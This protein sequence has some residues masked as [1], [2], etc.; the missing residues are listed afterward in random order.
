MKTEPYYLSRVAL[1]CF[2]LFFL[3]TPA[4]AKADKFLIFHLDAISAVDFDS[5]LQAG[6]LPNVQALFADGRYIKYGLSPFPGGTEIIYPRLKDGL[7]NSQHH[8]VAWSRWDR[9]ADQR[10]SNLTTWLE[11]VSGFPRRNKHQFL[12]A[13]PGLTHLAGL[14]LLNIERLWETEDVIEFFWFYTDFAGHL[15]GPEGHLKALRRFD[16]YL[17]LLLNTGRLNG[18]N[19]VLYTDHG[20][21]AGDVNRVD[22]KKII[23]ELLQDQLQ[24]IDYPNVYLQNPEHRIELAQKVIKHSE[25]DLVLVKANENIVR[26]FSSE[27]SFEIIKKGDTLQYLLKDGDFFDYASI[28]YEGEF[29]T[30]DEWLRFTKEHLYPGAIP[31][32]FG[33]VSN[34]VAGDIVL[35]ADYPNI[36]RT[37]TA[38]RGHHSGVRN[39]DLL[40]SLLYTGPAF[41][42]VDDF[43]EF[44]LHELYSH[45][46]TMIDFDAAPKREKSSI[47]LFYPLEAE[48]TLSPAH[49]WRG[50]FALASNRVEP[51]IEFDLYSSF[52]T[53]VWVGSAIA[54][55]KLR[56]QLRV[57][58]FLGDL[59]F[60]MIKRSG[61]KN[62]YS[63]GLR[64][65][66][67]VELEASGNRLGLTI[68]F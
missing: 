66:E 62:S 3:T 18:A 8:V 24:Y 31:N 63:I 44:W 38:L 32:L 13:V 25:I 19:V 9:E 65:G 21:M 22:F 41:A 57:E 17:G 12:L 54:D 60:A 33:F 59:R 51:W 39:T 29:L 35:V 48:M 11:M 53:K 15:L 5:E 26:G 68:I 56:W 52:L 23:P 16:Y 20:M 67:T 64:L 1:L 36:P 27:G 45:N 43:E 42:D 2:L 55:Q 28:G 30:R 14:S 58:A 37:L 6:N 40:V 34:P 61:A 4:Q 47:S 10:V 50:G 49:R 7:D 46:L